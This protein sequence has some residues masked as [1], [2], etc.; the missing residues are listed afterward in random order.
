MSGAILTEM[1]PALLRVSTLL[2]SLVLL[3]GY[4]PTADVRAA[5]TPLACV[6]GFDIVEGTSLVL[7]A[8]VLTT[9]AT[10]ALVA[11]SA[12]TAAGQWSARIARFADEGWRTVATRTPMPDAGLVAIDGNP[13]KGRWA[14]GYKRDDL[15]L[16]P[17][18]LRQTPNGRWKEAWVPR[19]GDEAAVLT[20][21]AVRRKNAV[22]AVGYRLDTA[23]TQRP[24]A[25]R[26]K[27][28]RWQKVGPPIGGRER[29]LLTAVSSTRSGGTWIA[30][31][32]TRSGIERPYVARR[33]AGAWKRVSLP[34]SG[35]G[36][37]TSIMVQAKTAGWAVGYRVATG[38]M[39]PLVL[40]WDGLRWK[41]IAPPV[42]PQESILLDVDLDH[43]QVVL[44]G[45]TWDGDGTRM[46]PIEARRSGTT[47][48]LSELKGFE[49]D[50]VMAD[51]DGARTDRGFLAARAISVGA[52]VRTC[53]GNGVGVAARKSTRQERR[54]ELAARDGQEVHP[55]EVEPAPRLGLAAAPRLKTSPRSAASVS[56]V[57]RAAA[58]GLPTAG[59]TYG[60]VVRDFD[61]DGQK[62]IFIGGHGGEAVL[63]LNEDGAFSP[64]PIDFGIADRHGCT[65][66][67]VD[68][69]G[70][71]D[72]Y[73]TFGGGRG[74][75]VK[76][77]EL[78]L[79]PGGSDARLAADAG[80]VRELLGRGRVATVL[81]WDDDGHKDLVVGQTPN[82]VDGLP[83]LNRIYRW[84]G[85]GRYQLARDSGI[86][87]AIGAREF[88]TGDFDRDGRV[89]L[90]M[91][92]FDAK[93][94][95]ALSSIRL[96][97]N[98]ATG[99]KGVHTARGI[100]S[101]GE[102]DAEL[103]GLDADDK[104]DLVQLSGN[105]IRIS[106]QRNGKFDR[107]YERKLS[108][109][110]ALAVGDADGDGDM[111]IYIL[112]HKKADSENDLI[113]FN[114]GNGRGYTAVEAPS[115]VGGSADQVY[116]I[117]HDGN[118]LT[119]FLVLNGRSGDQGPIQLIAFYDN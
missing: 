112:R 86:A 93:A 30:G 106:L 39:R 107:V 105:R 67:D 14:V 46:R 55:E 91:V 7:P 38:E 51:L 1:F 80:G 16:L 79:D 70:L 54:S 29:G 76:A 69:S 53:E 66:T 100:K 104:L 36:S 42:L 33:K 3:F 85:P 20:D 9:S 61:G 34:S 111:D 118:G 115:R 98:T 17:Y 2:V 25:V 103:V 88:D 116:P 75:G 99:L 57:D 59:P 4:T 65:A 81:D 56:I 114:A 35:A 68:G 22:W 23:G 45:T 28:K 102:R 44:S 48:K 62:D 40:R 12:R 41:T 87:P 10:S 13:T 31:S 27:G 82:R 5:E 109:A 101:I 92:S 11:G 52:L 47:W 64:S 74:L 84:V 96:Y 113:L 90:L 119:D 21:V 26:W 58:A 108:K 72:L 73:C 6:E 71:P 117:D 60:A 19:A 95:G 77:N 37:I 97:R 24:H 89:D 32:I 18:S 110:K 15:D 43:G 49:G 94:K 78:W 63:H 50:A 83:S 8:A